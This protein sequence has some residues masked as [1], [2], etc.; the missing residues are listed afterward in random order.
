MS[1]TQQ[2]APAG[3][4]NDGLGHQ[5]W[6]DGAQWGP[7]YAPPA[8]S[9]TSVVSVVGFILA[10]FVLLGSGIG[11]SALLGG[12]IALLLSAMGIP[13]TRAGIKSGRGLA[14]AGVVIACAGCAAAIGYGIL[15]G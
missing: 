6:W 11:Y 7:Y 8:T 3:W 13:D 9:P 15:R 4:Y 12:G 1:E 10:L 5:R 2:S 14:I